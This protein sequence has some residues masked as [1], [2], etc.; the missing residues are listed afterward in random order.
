LEAAL[1]EKVIRDGKVAVLVSPGF[2]AGWS[3]WASDEQRYAALFDKRF[4]DAAEAGIADIDSIAKEIFGEDYFFT[5]GWS[6]IEIEWIDEGSRF[7]I[8]EYDGSESLRFIS[9]LCITA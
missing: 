5:A 1:V 3:T 9:D 2:G 7:C 4:V 6:G 8:E